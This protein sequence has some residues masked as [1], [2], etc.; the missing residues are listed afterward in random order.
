MSDLDRIMLEAIR[1]RAAMPTTQAGTAAK[2]R[3]WLLD[4][5]DSVERGIRATIAACAAAGN[6]GAIMELRDEIDALATIAGLPGV[7]EVRDG[8]LGPRCAR[9][10]VTQP[11][12]ICLTMEAEA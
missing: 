1:H 10:M 2:D 4:Y 11:C 6:Y 9:H 3:A 12:A 7:D 8:P 5:L